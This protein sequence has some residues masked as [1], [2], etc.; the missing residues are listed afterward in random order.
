MIG[1][2]TD[3]E[4]K[5]IYEN[6]GPLR[7]GYNLLEST[8]WVMY[9]KSTINYYIQHLDTSWTNYKCKTISL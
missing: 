7:R 2:I 4:F 9:G 1:Q 8:A 3:S 6:A 5:R